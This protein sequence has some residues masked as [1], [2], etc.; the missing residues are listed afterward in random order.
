MHFLNIALIRPSNVLAYSLLA[1]STATA[2]PES[3]LPKKFITPSSRHF[4][5]ILSESTSA[6]RLSQW[7]FECFLEKGQYT[8]TAC[9]K[10]GYRRFYSNKWRRQP[11]PQNNLFH[12]DASNSTLAQQR[13]TTVVKPAKRRHARS[14]PGA[15]CGAPCNQLRRHSCWNVSFAIVLCTGDCGD[16]VG[17]VASF[18]VGSSSAVIVSHFV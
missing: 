13:L 15:P 5:D 16:A 8:K 17:V 1:F 3:I 4:S 12:N 2:Y 11:Y 6:Q 7:F 10:S 18:C 14:A 9:Q